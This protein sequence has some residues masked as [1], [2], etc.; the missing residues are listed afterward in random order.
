MHAP[1][2]H[3]TPAMFLRISPI[4]R[5]AAGTLHPGFDRKHPPQRT[6]FINLF[7]CKIILI[8][9]A[10]LVYRKKHSG[11]FRYIKYLLQFYG[12]KR[13]RL[14][15]HHIFPRA[16]CG[17]GQIFMAVIRH[18]QGHHFHT[19]ISKKLPKRIICMEPFLLC[20]FSAQRKDIINTADFPFLHG[21][22][23]FY[24][25]S[26]HAPIA[27]DRNTCFY[28]IHMNSSSNDKFCLVLCPPHLGDILKRN[29]LFE[30]FHRLG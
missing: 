28:S 27:H 30:E 14:F 2:K 29:A 9:T 26:A 11:F 23:F 24:M 6:I 22:Q 7:Q 20:S 4:S 16:H 10:V 1:V 12:R 13:H 25:P 17:D 18:S 21:G 15:A 5:N 19:G 3:H 8:P